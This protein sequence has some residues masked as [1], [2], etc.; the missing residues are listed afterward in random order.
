M[1]NIKNIL[2]AIVIL[3]ALSACNSL[4]DVE[5]KNN[6]T[7]DIYN[8]EDGIQKALNAAYFNLGGINDG[9][10]GG[11]L[12]GGDFIII[13]SLLAIEPFEVTWDN[14]SGPSYSDFANKDIQAINARLEA[15][16]RRAYEIINTL[17]SIL[18]NLE[19]VSAS[20]RDKIE[21][22]TLAMRGILYFELVRLWGP[23]YRN[24]TGADGVI[25]I[26]DP[27]IP[28]L[29]DPIEV[30]GSSPDLNTVGEV[31]DQ[32]END[33]TNASTLLQPF[34]K[35]GDNLSYYV[36]QAY[37]MRKAMHE[38]DYNA[39][40]T[41]A[42]NIIGGPFD[43]ALTPQAAFNNTSNSVEDIFAV[44]QTAGNNAGNISTGTGITNYYSS[45]NNQGLGAMRVSS[46][47]LT[48]LFGDFEYSPEFSSNDLRGTVDAEV[49]TSADP[50]D[51]NDPFY[52]N[53]LNTSVLSPGKYL[54]SNT[55][56]PV[57]RLAE[58][59]L[60]RAEA[61]AF[62]SP[63]TV[64]PVALEDYNAI[65]ARAGLIEYDASDFFIGVDLYDSILVERRREFLY[66]GI[67]FHDMKRRQESID[68]VE[69]TDPKFILP[70]PQSEQ[71]A[72]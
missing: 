31:Y 54:A 19:N 70:I 8:T 3:I 64:D 25:T 21:G 55:V 30:P 57:I 9:I 62:L 53:V 10:D 39:A 60:T 71:D 65:R 4:L 22:E 16:W 50:S 5:A 47:Y 49:S 18:Q 33:L 36:C 11:E 17:N 52:Q 68:G 40:I 69:L 63:G 15:N 45:L 42:N 61:R 56:I 43:L 35:N 51:I 37:L 46:F 6:V 66:E 72:G 26:N 12:F 23:E 14:I 38:S 28:I 7:G 41:Y 34:G 59:F 27:A 1:R 67:L 48:D 13:P 24:E 58:V 44:Q 2:S 32:V 29:L 20:K